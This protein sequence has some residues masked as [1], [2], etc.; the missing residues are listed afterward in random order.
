M[1]ANKSNLKKYAKQLLANEYSE[2]KEKELIT[3]CLN[4]FERTYGHISHDRTAHLEQID[5]ILN[6]HGVEGSMEPDIQYCNA[7]E[8]YAL[9]ILY[10]QGKLRIGNWG[11]IVERATN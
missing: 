4:G 3:V 6:T 5:K 10:Y 8:T 1:I 9:T 2:A 7:G 11:D